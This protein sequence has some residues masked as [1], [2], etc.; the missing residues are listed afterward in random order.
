MK[1]VTVIFILSLSIVSYNAFFI[2]SSYLQPPTTGNLI[3]LTDDLTDEEDDFEED[4]DDDA[5]AANTNQ[6]ITSVVLS[7][8]GKFIVITQEDANSH[9]RTYLIFSRNALTE[10]FDLIREFRNLA[11]FGCD[12]ESIFFTTEHEDSDGLI[13]DVDHS[14]QLTDLAP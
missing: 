10:T 4:N 3:Q 13:T 14:I 9:E 7:A 1:Q 2:P 5:I 11:N 6:R 12:G 8:D